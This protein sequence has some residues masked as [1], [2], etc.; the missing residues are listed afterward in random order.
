MVFCP[1]TTFSSILSLLKPCTFLWSPA[2]K[3]VPSIILPNKSNFFLLRSIFSGVI[4]LK[5][6]FFQVYTQLFIYKYLCLLG[7]KLSKC[8][9]CV[10]N[11]NIWWIKNKCSCP[12]MWIS[13]VN[14]E[15]DSNINHLLSFTLNFPPILI[16]LYFLILF[17][18]IMQKMLLFWFHRR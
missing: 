6:F 15:D 3:P 14:A 17:H 11:I 1:G 5:R 2:Q 16:L 8:I 10:C 9:F 18:N 13:V 7:C 12:A 4:L